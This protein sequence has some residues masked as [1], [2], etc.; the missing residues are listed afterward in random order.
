[1]LSREENELLCR[2]GPGTQMGAML[3]RYWMPAFPSV[4]LEAGGAPRRLRLLGEDLVA[5]RSPSG[6]VGV[7]DESCPH[8]GASLRL[9]RNEECGLRCLYHG[10]KIDPTGRVLETPPEPEELNFKER[11]RAVAYPCYEAGGLVW[12]Y[13]GPLGTEPA[14][15][16]FE[17]T[18]VPE[19]DRMIT[20]VWSEC[21]FVQALEGVLDSSHSNYLHSDAIKPSEGGGATLYSSNRRAFDMDRP[22]RDGQPRI[23]VDD[24][25]YGFR[26]GA[27][28]IPVH[29]ADTMRYVRV[30]HFMAPFYTVV[31]APKGTGWQHMFVPID[32]ENT[33]FR[34]VRF[35]TD[36][37]PLTDE[38]RAAH[39][40]WGGTTRGVDVDLEYRKTR[41]AENNWLPRCGAEAGR[42]LPEPKTKISRSR[43]AWAGYSTAPKSIL[44]PPTSP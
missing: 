12:T 32:D 10:W 29:N 1:M 14:R 27:I 11:V 8:R 13:M 18:T 15:P 38:D 19:S 39:E 24:A 43:K 2:V 36:G 9:A 41:Q 37:V 5:F 26:Y 35:K 23:E 44:A 34:Y 3:R 25:R 22:S 6:D 28:R 17:F 40:R 33:M 42:G 4:D 7:L 16:D 30:T 21:N 20:N 31:P